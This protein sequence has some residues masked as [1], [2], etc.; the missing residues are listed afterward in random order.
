MDHFRVF[1]H[2]LIVFFQFFFGAKHD[3]M[4][5]LAIVGKHKTNRLI[6]FCRNIVGCKTHR[7][8]H[9]D[10]YRTR[11]VFGVAGLADHIIAR[12]IIAMRVN[13]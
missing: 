11:D 1:I 6:L 10:L 2:H 12:M 8:G 9:A 4:Y 13:Q 5:E 7:V 3:F